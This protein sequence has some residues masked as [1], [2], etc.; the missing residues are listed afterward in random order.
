MN[1]TAKKE[2][3]GI[4]GT[5]SNEPPQ[6]ATVNQQANQAGVATNNSASEDEKFGANLQRVKEL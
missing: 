6:E 1:V 2:A 4:P 5:I 3:M